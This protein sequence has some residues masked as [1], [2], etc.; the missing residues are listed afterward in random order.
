MTSFLSLLAESTESPA[1]TSMREITH[2][3]STSGGEL[4]KKFHGAG[5]DMQVAFAI[6]A[7]IVAAFIAIILLIALRRHPND[8]GPIDTLIER[9]DRLEVSQRES[10]HPAH[11]ASELKG[12]VGYFKQELHELRQLCLAI[13]HQQVN[14]SNTHDRDLYA[15]RAGTGGIER[16]RNSHDL[17]STDTRVVDENQS[18]N[19]LTPEKH[20]EEISPRQPHSARVRVG[21][22]PSRVVA[23]ARAA[24]SPSVSGRGGFFNAPRAKL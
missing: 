4:L 6:G 22:I 16:R 23:E 14:A 3:V 8:S 17:N 24:Y 13:H 10:G 19:T 11:L 20:I 21:E 9:L 1:A 18:A 5:T 2:A 15:S 7:I 12:M